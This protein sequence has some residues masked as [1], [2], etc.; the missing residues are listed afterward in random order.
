MAHLIVTLL[1]LSVLTLATLDFT[2]AQAGVCYGRQGNGLPSPADVVSL[3]NR[4]NIRRMRI[5]DPDQP[6]L[7]ALRGSNI[8]LMLGV[9][10][11][12]LEN[13]AAS[14]AN[15][16]TWVQNNVRNYG[17]VKFRYIAVGNEVS[18]LN[19]NSKYVPVLL[20]AMRNI[21]TAIS[22]AGLGNQIKVSTAI[23]TGLTTD[24]SPPSNGRFK[25][26]VRQFIEPIIN[27]LVTNRAPLLVNLYP[28]FAIANN[29][30]IK[31]EYALFTSSEVVV[32]DNGRGYRNLFDAILDATYSALEKASG[33]SLEIVVSES[34]WPSAGAGQLTSIDNART[35][36]NNLISHVKGGSPK[37]P[38]G[39]IETYVFALFD[40]DQKDPE[41]EKHF[42]LFSANMQ[43]KY[44]I[45]FN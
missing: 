1:L 3:C 41:I 24:T 4:N 45:S 12:D 26:D 31:L 22:G 18:P 15:A 14:Q 21:Q 13:V 43:P 7:E 33:S 29:A 16:D 5:Y 20:N 35:Y 6:T 39:P 23:E 40:E 11:P 25:D 37:R 36:N 28:Y 8:E 10:N 32:N 42:G 17:N 38:S 19:E 2:G 44:Q 30:D 27:F 34:G 9:P